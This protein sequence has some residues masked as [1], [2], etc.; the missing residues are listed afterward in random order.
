[1]SGNGETVWNSTVDPQGS[2]VFF[3]AGAVGRT[4]PSNRWA[5]GQAV[6]GDVGAGGGGNR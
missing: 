6:A 5:G 3:C 2:R 1:M 4:A